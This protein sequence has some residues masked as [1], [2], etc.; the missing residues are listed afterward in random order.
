MSED[1]HRHAP[2][3]CKVV[4]IVYAGHTIPIFLFVKWS[5]W[6]RYYYH[7]LKDEKME[8]LGVQALEHPV[9][10]FS[11]LTL[12]PSSTFPQE[13][14]EA[15][16]RVKKASARGPQW[17]ANDQLSHS[18]R[19]Q[20]TLSVQDVWGLQRE[21]A[22]SECQAQP[23]SICVCPCQGTSSTG[24]RKEEPGREGP[25]RTSLPILCILHQML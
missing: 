17:C 14:V 8:V 15:S 23:W 18:A 16:V 7:Y 22:T 20:Q 13:E 6:D 21:R 3:C 11:N 10:G 24:L 5:R 2:C 1:I 4:I 12:L 25:G 19:T 9:R